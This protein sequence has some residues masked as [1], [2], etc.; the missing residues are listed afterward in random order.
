MRFLVLAADYDG[1]L[2][3]DGHVDESV[4]RSL[5]RLKESGRKLVLVTGRELDD[6]L[7]VFP[8]FELF[9]RVVA[10]NGAVLYRPKTREEKVL[11]ERPPEAFVAALRE[12]GVAPLSVGRAIVSTRE[13]HQT[14]VLEMI[15]RFG[16]ELHVI[17]NKG[18]VMILPS[19]V[20]KATGLVVALEEL[21]LSA[22][23]SVAAGD[24]ENDHAMMALCECAVAVQNALP[25]AKERADFVTAGDHGA[26]VVEV[27]EKLLADDLAQL[28]PKMHR[29]A[30]LLGKVDT[31]RDEKVDPQDT[32]ILV[33][34][35]SGSGKSRVTTGLLE[36]FGERGYQYVIIDP[37]GDYASLEGAVVL[38]DPRTAPTVEAILELLAPP[39]QNVVVNLLGISLEHRPAFFMGLLPHLQELRAR[40][41][42]PHWIV[43]D[44]AHHLLP[45]EQ[46]QSTL[47]LPHEIRG[48]FFITV[49]PGS[50]A[51]PVLK[52]VDLVLAVG[53]ATHGT[54]EAFCKAIGDSPPRL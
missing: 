10:E 46:T 47:T 54:L 7:H 33:A 29:H 14:V 15:R 11:C 49:H 1:T 45:A 41:G 30:I 9:D 53:K 13:P 18:A 32:N 19:G 50:I 31:G 40:T 35:T 52:A 51:Q 5:K 37:E 2:A 20:N 38:G 36:R 17:F 8:H 12:R 27:I 22:H 48:M 24:A 43:V 23:N 42:R 21:S 26:G 4:L 3:R 25:Q 28:A 39:H 16:L 34:G 44:E 6:L